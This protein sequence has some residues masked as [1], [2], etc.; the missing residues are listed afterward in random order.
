MKRISAK[1]IH[2]KHWPHSRRINADMK[3]KLL[4]STTFKPC[5]YIMLVLL[6]KIKNTNKKEHTKRGILSKI[7]QWLDFP[8][9][10][11]PNLSH[12][13]RVKEL[14]PR[15]Q[16]LCTSQTK[17]NKKLHFKIIFQIIIPNYMYHYHPFMH[18][19]VN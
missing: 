7:I 11:T 2:E 6:N 4:E 17:K 15:D 3:Q 1:N 9:Y 8:S 10:Q 18:N 13:G 12:R 19:V 5:H 16:F 14:T